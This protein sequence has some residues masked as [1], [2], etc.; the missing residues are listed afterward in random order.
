M[1]RQVSET[2]IP[3]TVL[4]GTKK[5]KALLYVTMENFYKLQMF[6]VQLRYLSCYAI[7]H[8]SRINYHRV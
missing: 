4:D 2:A 3:L 8:T 6:Y 1:S 5:K 7:N